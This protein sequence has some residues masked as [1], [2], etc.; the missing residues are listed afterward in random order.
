MRTVRIPDDVADRCRNATALLGLT[1]SGIDLRR[2]PQDEWF[3]LEAN[4]SPGYTYYQRLV[5]IA[6]PLTQTLTRP[7]EAATTEQP[8]SPAGYRYPPRPLPNPA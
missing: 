5:D 1:F 4:T 2:T 8:S 7:G 6:H 3:C